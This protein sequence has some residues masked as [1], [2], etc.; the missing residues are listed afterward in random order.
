MIY[1]KQDCRKT[2]APFLLSREVCSMELKENRGVRYDNRHSALQC[3]TDRSNCMFPEAT[4]ISNVPESSAH[5]TDEVQS[6]RKAMQ[7]NKELNS[8]RKSKPEQ[9]QSRKLQPS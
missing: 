3:L 2:Q 5:L 9:C 1:A 7:T 6:K 8:I 4:K